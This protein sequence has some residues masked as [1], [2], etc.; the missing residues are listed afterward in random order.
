MVVNG[1]IGGMSFEIMPSAPGLMYPKVPHVFKIGEKSQKYTMSPADAPAAMIKVWQ[2][3]E[4]VPGWTI[5]IQWDGRMV[6]QMILPRHERG[7]RLKISQ[8]MIDWVD[9]KFTSK[10]AFKIFDHG[11]ESLPVTFYFKALGGVFG[12]DDWAATETLFLFDA[13]LGMRWAEPKEIV[14]VLDVIGDLCGDAVP[15]GDMPAPLSVV[16]SSAKNHRSAVA[17]I[18][19]KVREGIGFILRPVVNLYRGDGSR[20]MYKMEFDKFELIVA[21]KPN[22]ILPGNLGGRA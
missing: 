15:R 11:F 7:S 8:E 22:L 20:V 4:K 21:G 3:E 19:G 9:E 10:A 14:S 13:R 17:E 16:A 1:G 6:N 5:A 18:G 12:L 2:A